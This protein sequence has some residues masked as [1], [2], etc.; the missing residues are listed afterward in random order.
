M[1]NGSNT[2]DEARLDVSARGFWVPYQKAFFD[3]RAFNPLAGRYG[4]LSINKAFEV[5]EK[6]KKKSYNDRV[7]QVER[8]KFTPLVFSA[9][10]GKGLE[11]V[12]FYQRLCHMIADKRGVNYNI[13]MNWINRKIA[14]A[15]NTCIIMCV[16]GS[17]STNDIHTT[18]TNDIE[19]AE[20]I[21]KTY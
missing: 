7:L 18:T 1:T 8:G 17:R 19:I 14:F 20:A 21:S 12:K 3:V 16:R 9:N 13:T 5:N 15:L 10:G 4:N 11:C 6:E 2:T